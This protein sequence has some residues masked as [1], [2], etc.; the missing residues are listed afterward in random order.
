MVSVVLVV[1]LVVLGMVLVIIGAVACHYCSTGRLGHRQY[2][3]VGCKHR[4]PQAAANVQSRASQ[5]PPYRS[6]T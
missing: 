5:L 4:S 2:N 6:V 1:V 3:R